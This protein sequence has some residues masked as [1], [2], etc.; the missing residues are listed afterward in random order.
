MKTSIVTND[1]LDKVMD[2]SKESL[3]LAKDGLK[4]I[5][6][7][8]HDLVH[9]SEALLNFSSVWPPFVQLTGLKELKTLA[10]LYVKIYGKDKKSDQK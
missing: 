7:L 6:Q 9:F 5:K 2:Q 4:T 3:K 10:E 1:F 8:E